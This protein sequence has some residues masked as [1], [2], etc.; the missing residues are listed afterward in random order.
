MEE[1]N[2]AGGQSKALFYDFYQT[3]LWLNRFASLSDLTDSNFKLWPS[4]LQTVG[5]ADK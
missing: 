4:V 3:D 2:Q 1:A 5:G